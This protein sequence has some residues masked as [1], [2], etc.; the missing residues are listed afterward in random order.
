MEIRGSWWFSGHLS[1]WAFQCLYNTTSITIKASLEFRHV[2]S[3]PTPRTPHHNQPTFTVVLCFSKIFWQTLTL[4]R[5]DQ[6]NTCPPGSC[7]HVYGESCSLDWLVSILLM[8]RSYKSNK[9]PMPRP[10]LLLSCPSLHW[11]ESWVWRHPSWLSVSLFSAAPLPGR[12]CN[13][14]NNNLLLEKQRVRLFI[15]SDLLRNPGWQSG[16]AV[17]MKVK[18]SSSE[19]NLEKMSLSGSS[20]FNRLGSRAENRLDKN[21]RVGKRESP[22]KVMRS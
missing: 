14:R 1:L 2:Y 16:Q 19:A 15:F 20:V 6:W 5:F 21:S 22:R 12:H 17:F 10:V 8:V 9:C 4:L 7:T 11:R 18:K 3:P 13:N